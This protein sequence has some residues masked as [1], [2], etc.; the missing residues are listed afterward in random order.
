ME[1]LAPVL[2]DDLE[3][4]LDG[5][6]PARS[7]VLCDPERVRD[8]GRRPGGDQSGV[9]RRLLGGGGRG[10]RPPRVDLDAPH[11]FARSP[12][13]ANTRSARAAVVVGQPVATGDSELPRCWSRRQRPSPGHARRR[14]LPRRHARGRSRTPGSGWPPTG[15][16]RMCSTARVR[17]ARR[18]AE[19]LGTRHPGPAGR[20][21]D[22][23]ADPGRRRRHLRLDSSSGFVD[24]TKLAVL[25][26][27]D[28]SGQRVAPPRTCSRLPSRRRNAI[29]PLAAEARR[30]R[31]ARAARRRPVRRDGAAHRDGAT[32]STWS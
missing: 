27:T 17:P 5:C 4:L 20:G 22:R 9:P 13:C 23:A 21:P 28:L 7:V 12:T 11:R 19:V 18:H 6:R 24:E 31:R 14:G 1:S 15:G 30:L 10:R 25:T 2:V 32:A 8:P 3:L 26:E 16:S 29:D